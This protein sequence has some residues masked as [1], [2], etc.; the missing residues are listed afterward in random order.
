M[1]PYGA[2]T[3]AYH[4]IGPLTCRG[5]VTRRARDAAEEPERKVTRGNG[6]EGYPCRPPVTWRPDMAAF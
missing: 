3:T 1:A 4:T 6:A 2:E 5:K